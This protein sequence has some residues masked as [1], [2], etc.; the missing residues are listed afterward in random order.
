L[1]SN[2]VLC[3]GKK[4]VLFREIGAFKAYIRNIQLSIKQHLVA[5]GC[6]EKC[7]KTKTGLGL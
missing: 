2:T 3:G 1:V 7:S 6:I 4:L 5:L